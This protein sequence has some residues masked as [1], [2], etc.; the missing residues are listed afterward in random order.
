MTDFWT[1]FNLGLHHM[2]IFFA[3]EH[4][5]FFLALTVPYDFNS[6]K[7][8]LVLNFIFTLGHT[9]SIFLAVF[10]IVTV[11]ANITDIIILLTI[12]IIA[13]RNII[14]SG[15]ASKK[16][17]FPFI[18]I[19]TAFLGI[20]HGLGYSN[21]FNSILKVSPTD[22]LLPLFESSLGMFSGQII[23]VIL[24]LLIGYVI[25]TLFKFSKRDWTLTI[26]AFIV[27]VVIPMILQNEIWHK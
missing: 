20:I 2:L 19:A 22:K 10:N 26:S 14:F 25:Q 13:F 27:G 23:I 6:W 16:S 12:F 3:Y 9:L 1:Y 24:A 8:L 21:Y 18:E 5:L 15:K 7:K 17:T 11:K 4:I